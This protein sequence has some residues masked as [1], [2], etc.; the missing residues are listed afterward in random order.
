MNLPLSLQ[1]EPDGTGVIKLQGCQK[2][3]RKYCGKNQGFL[4]WEVGQIGSFTKNPKILVTSHSR[5]ILKVRVTKKP[6]SIA[7]ILVTLKS[8]FKW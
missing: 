7:M 6:Y 2:F 4:Y 1:S 3:G 8:H 5:R